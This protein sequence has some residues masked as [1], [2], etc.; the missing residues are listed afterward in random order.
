[1]DAHCPIKLEVVSE[2][3]EVVVTDLEIKQQLTSAIMLRERNGYMH[4]HTMQSRPKI[5]F[6]H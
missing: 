4:S 2:P 5:K 6:A 3:S 1:M